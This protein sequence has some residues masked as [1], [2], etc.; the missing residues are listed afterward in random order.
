MKETGVIVN[1]IW[2]LGAA[3]LTVWLFTER[4]ACIKLAQESLALRQQ[5]RS[6]EALIAENRRLS[7]LLAQAKHF[8]SRSN[9]GLAATPRV[10]G[11]A[12]E[13]SR[14]RAEVDALRQQTNQIETLREDTRQARASLEV[15]LKA[16]S[17]GEVAKPGEGTTPNG[18]RLEILKAE[19]WTDNA[20]MDVT[21]VLRNRIKGDSLKAV[22]S[23]NIKGDPD[24]GQVKHLTIQ[25][26]FGGITA[27]NEFRE[28]DVIVL[29]TEQSQ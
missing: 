19:Y 22:A 14:L 6:T 27:T 11:P 21:D 24:F 5:L 3:G 13:L 16:Q 26:R 12:E 7:K 28:G 9:V 17:A 18:S 8:S 15:N 2:G 23:N 4:Q 29:P 1:I 25:Y 10:D 20:R